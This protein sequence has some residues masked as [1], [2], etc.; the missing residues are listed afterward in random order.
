MARIPPEQLPQPV[1]PGQPG[2]PGQP[3]AGAAPATAPGVTGGSTGY[4]PGGFDTGGPRKKPPTALIAGIAG[5]VVVVIAIVVVL[6]LTLGGDKKG[7]PQT[8]ASPTN[9]P[10]G[11]GGSSGG[12][13]SQAKAA[14]NLMVGEVAMPGGEY[15][16]VVDAFG[17]DASLADDVVA[18]SAN[19]NAVADLLVNCVSSGTIADAFTKDLAGQYPAGSIACIRSSIT[20]MD[21]G[22]LTELLAALIDGDTQT[23]TSILSYA[24][25]GC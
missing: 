15:Q 3:V 16:C 22:S 2:Q 1:Y 21:Q 13:G 14:A 11:N 19:P 20:S 9:A 24:A 5:A 25:S 18:Q 8:S 17:E 23:A 4:G 10:S 12:G 6:V 7:G